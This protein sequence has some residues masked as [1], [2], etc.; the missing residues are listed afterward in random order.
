MLQSDLLWIAYGKAL[1]FNGYV[2]KTHPS[3]LRTLHG[4]CATIES[5]DYI[6]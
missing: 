6:A 5:R 4:S 1:K 3:E 2:A